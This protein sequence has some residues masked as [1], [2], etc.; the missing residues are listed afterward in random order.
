MGTSDEFS[1]LCLIQFLSRRERVGAEV[2]A[3][4]IKSGRKIWQF[5]E[6]VESR[7]SMGWNALQPRLVSAL[8]R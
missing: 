3:P 4:P 7:P 1:S 2:L 8:V 5:E 6:R